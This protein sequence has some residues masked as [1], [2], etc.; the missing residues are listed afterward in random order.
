V[1][2]LFLDMDGVLNSWQSA[3]YFWRTKHDRKSFLMQWDEL[4]PIACSNLNYLLECVPDLK[5]VISST[6][7]KFHELPEWDAKMS[8]ICPAIVGRVIG[9]TPQLPGEERGDE[10][11]RWLIEN[12]HL[13]TPYVV[14]D[15][16][17]DMGA[18]L[19]RFV[20]TDERLGLTWNDVSNICD[21]FCV[22]PKRG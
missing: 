4:C 22:I 1:K 15:D 9:K 8:T 10:I 19:D 18:V 5:I 6:W 21:K 16:N 12:D 7:R 11:Y 20:Q 14:V 17:D 3:E 13:A 2:L